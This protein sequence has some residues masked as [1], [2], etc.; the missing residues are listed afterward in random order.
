MCAS[1]LR[2]KFNCVRTHHKYSKKK[3]KKTICAL[4]LQYDPEKG[5][6]S[7]QNDAFLSKERNDWIASIGITFTNKK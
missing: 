7:S 2:H 4:S 1:K 5:F 6:R 3:K